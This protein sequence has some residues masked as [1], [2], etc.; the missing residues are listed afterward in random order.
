MDLIH[1][2]TEIT[3]KTGFQ[4]PNVSRYVSGKLKP[5]DA[6][7]RKFCEVYKLDYKK[8]KKSLADNESQEETMEQKD[9]KI[10]TLETV[11]NEQK[12]ALS[13]LQAQMKQMQELMKINFAK[14]EMRDR[15]LIT[16]MQQGFELIV[17]SFGQSSS[18]VEQDLKTGNKPGALQ[19]KKES[20]NKK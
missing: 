20:T 12:T 4:K 9:E 3:A 13:E 7:L 6:F 11:I 19:K 14:Q 8:T 2:V 1:P 16:Q 10:N 5:S 17:S 18:L 15:N